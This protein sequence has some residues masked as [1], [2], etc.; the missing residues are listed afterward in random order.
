MTMFV[1]YGI[2]RPNTYHGHQMGYGMDAK[3]T[4]QDA[5]ETADDMTLDYDVVIVIEVEDRCDVPSR[6]DWR[7][8]GHA[9]YTIT[10]DQL[11]ERHA[12]E[13]SV[14]VDR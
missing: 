9:K 10:R 12:K 1:V 3:D 13:E 6:I 7:Q 4:F 11:K 2:G 5:K 14:Y 8:L